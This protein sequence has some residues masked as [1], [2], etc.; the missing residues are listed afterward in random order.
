MVIRCQR[1][2]GF[3]F[4]ETIPATILLSFGVGIPSVSQDMVP[5]SSL[6]SMIAFA[7][8]LLDS[9]RLGAVIACVPV[10]AREYVTG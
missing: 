9:T 7:S 4:R 10:P 6:M 1:R 8:G 5:F 2:T 3:Q